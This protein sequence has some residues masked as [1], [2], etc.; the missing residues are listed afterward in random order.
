MY[1]I[2]EL[3][4]EIANQKELGDHVLMVTKQKVTIAEHK[5][6]V[7]NKALED[8]R[9]SAIN[10]INSLD[11]QLDSIRLR[12]PKTVSCRNTVSK[13][14]S[15]GLASQETTDNYKFSTES[16]GFSQQQAREANQVAADLNQC[17]AFV[18]SLENFN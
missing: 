18:K 13:D 4:H 7:V 12:Q 11:Q 6:L 9:A 17:L 1:Q 10:T 3:Q 8:S 5:Q 2:S 15:T 14:S 16:L